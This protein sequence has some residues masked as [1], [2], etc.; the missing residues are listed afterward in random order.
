MCRLPAISCLFVA[1]FLSGVLRA[2]TDFSADIV[3]ARQPG[4]VTPTLARIY[5]AKD[6]RRIEMLGASGDSA[7]VVKLA[8]RDGRNGVELK[9]AGNKNTIIMDLASNT[10]TLLVALDKAY[11][12]APLG[13]M[14]PSE[15]YGLYAFVRP[16]NVDNAC[17]EW[18]RRSG[19]EGETCRNQGH[20]TING[21]NTVKYDLSCYGEVCHLWIDLNLHALVKR[22]SKWTSTELRNIQE[23]PQ[24]DSIFE[25]PAGYTL[26]PRVGGVIGRREPQ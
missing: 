7:I 24:P 11:Y 13:K 19:A 22:E 25:V 20:E 2:Q 5:S 8:Q 1:L 23:V 6:K 9:V 17:V 10:S 3:D 4:P 18:M 15:M 21:R 14:A 26:M 16:M 12:E